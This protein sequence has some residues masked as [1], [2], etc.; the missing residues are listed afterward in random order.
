MYEVPVKV[1]AAQMSLGLNEGFRARA[2]GVY[3]VTLRHLGLDM[4]GIHVQRHPSIID[5]FTSTQATLHTVMFQ[6]YISSIT[7][8]NVRPYTV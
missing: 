7:T 6:H 4:R 2:L 3:T 1:N 5:I 8:N